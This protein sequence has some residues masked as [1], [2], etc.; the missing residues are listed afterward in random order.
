MTRF[1]ED[2]WLLTALG[3]VA[4]FCACPGCTSFGTSP[5]KTIANPHAIS[6]PTSPSTHVGDA[7]DQRSSNGPNIESISTIATSEEPRQESPPRLLGSAESGSGVL[8]LSVTEAV[9]NALSNNLHLRVIADLPEEAGKRTEIEQAQ[10]DMSFN[11]NVQYLQGTQQVASALQAVQGGQSQYGTTSIGPVAGTPNLV[12]L[13]Q[14]FSTG[15]TARIGLGSNYNYNSPMGQYL[16]YNPAYQSAGSLVIEQAIFRG[17]NRQANL[18]GMHIAEAGQK[19]SAAEFQIEVNQ[20]LT[21]VQRAYWL[22]WLAE[23]QLKTYEEFVE[24]A[25]ATHALEQK[26][27]EIGKGG[28]V[29][30][31]Q[32]TENLHSLKAELAQAQ[33]RSRAAR[34]HLFTLMGIPPEDQRPLQM[35][36]EPLAKPVTPDLQQGLAIAA[37]QRPEIQV[38][39]FQVAQ[40]QLELER[41]VNNERPDVRAYAG[42]A[43]TGLNNNLL[44]SVNQFGSGQFGNM[45]LGV[46]YTYLFGQRA[47]RAASEQ[48]RMAFARQTRARQ[49]TEYLVQQQVRDAWDAVNSSWEVL[50]CQQERVTAARVQSE[51]FGQ[52]YDAGQIDLDRLLRARQQ[53]AS[54]V[55]QSHGA[56][57]EYNLA[58]NGW[59]FATGAVTAPL[60]PIEDHPR[61]V[62]VAAGNWDE[63]VDPPDGSKNLPQDDLP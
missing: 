33:Q 58:L 11:S 30:V 17:A 39:Q 47:E 35:T 25:Q 9:A 54:A 37:Q 1:T 36:D 28:I 23:S 43:L 57:I 10:F 40:A 29:P 52:L 42:Y 59:R 5:K 61:N 55:Q 3:L 56:L 15:T 19:Q 49:E 53:L 32:A 38:R 21:D 51:T 62:H 2:R 6:S 13:E 8:A 44:G 22:A 24:Q 16:L 48:A 60:I 4:I 7:V 20:T 50:R 14:K 18:A 31:A 46:R 27:F 12:S 26:R 34:N 41:R 45:S 63:P